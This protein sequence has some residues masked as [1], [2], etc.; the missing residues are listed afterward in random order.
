MSEHRDYF[1]KE[2]HSYYTRRVEAQN[3]EGKC[4][5]LIIDGMDQ[6]HAAIPYLFSSEDLKRYPVRITGVIAHGLDDPFF[7]F[8]NTR[9]RG[10]SNANIHVLMTIFDK[11][12]IF[13]ASFCRLA[14]TSCPRS[15]TSKWITH[16]RITEITLF[17]D[18]L[19]HWSSRGSWMRYS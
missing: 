16:A 18:S 11:V 6:H 2:R 3:S 15:C 9:N 5:C 1:V 8:I 13:L 7:A 17:R 12:P 19:R 4:L 14:G 10:D